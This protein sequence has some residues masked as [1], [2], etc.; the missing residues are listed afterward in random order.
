MNNEKENNSSLDSW[1]DYIGGTF[2]K[3]A[4]VDSDEDQYVILA[5]SQGVD[6]DG[7][8]KRIRLHLQRNE[9]E[10]EFDLNKT[11]SAR[12]K[13]L[14]AESP[15]SLIG[16]KVSFKKVLVRNPKTN[17]EVESLRINKLE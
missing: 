4:N 12:L 5:V 17:L 2:L 10:V 9:I 15:K 16:K 6:L 3:A 7:Q 11:N 14:G 13:E 1:N 8:G